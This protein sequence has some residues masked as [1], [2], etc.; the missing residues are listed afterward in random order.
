MIDTKEEK[1]MNDFEKT[2]K[3]YIEKACKT[4]AQLAQKYAESGKD[5]Q[6]CCKHIIEV[7]RT[8]KTGKCCVMTDEEVFGIAIHFF[9]E[10][11]KAP[12]KAATCAERAEVM[13]SEERKPVVKPKASKS[14]VDE[15]QLSL[16]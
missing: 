4:D 12:E 14:V 16:F 8:K 1:T 2:I 3:D 7:A 15:L 11:L 6:G 5:I 13:R 10:G 9:V